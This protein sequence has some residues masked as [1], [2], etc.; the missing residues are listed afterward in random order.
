MFLC[1]LIDIGIEMIPL[2]FVFK[3]N[4]NKTET[5]GS[6]MIKFGANNFEMG[7]LCR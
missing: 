4:Q 1:G 3:K 5:N 6:K 7:A 2:V